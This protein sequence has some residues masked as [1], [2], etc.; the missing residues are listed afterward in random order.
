[1]IPARAGFTTLVRCLPLVSPDHPRSRG[2]YN[3][4]NFRATVADGSSPLARGLPVRDRH[5]AAVER[6]IPARAGFTAPGTPVTSPVADHPRSRGVYRRR[7]RSPRSASGS[8]PL[9]RGLRGRLLPLV[10]PRRIIPARAGFTAGPPSGIAPSADH[11]RSRGVYRRA[12]GTCAAGAG[13]SPLAR[14]LPPPSRQGLTGMGIIPARAGFTAGNAGHHGSFRDHPRS[15]GVYDEAADKMSHLTG[16]SPLARGLP[17]TALGERIDAGIIPARAG[18]TPTAAAWRAS[19][20]DH[21]R[22]RG[23]YVRIHHM[24]WQNRGS[25]PLAR[26]LLRADLYDDLADRIIP[27]RAG[28]TFQHFRPRRRSGDHPRSRGVYT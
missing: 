26:G 12:C 5:H 15:R 11:P 27:A 23:V 22:S 17:D 20:P 19:G 16:S 2:V 4:V 21:P 14:G 28:F 9:A 10:A 6:I 24:T 7:F 13:S 18:F 3:T 8:S 25:S 1:M